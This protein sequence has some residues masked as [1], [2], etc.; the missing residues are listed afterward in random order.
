[1]IWIISGPTSVGKST[2]IARPRSAE[3][4]GLPRGTPVVFAFSKRMA[5][6]LGQT[7]AILHYNILR[8]LQ[9]LR[10][11]AGSADQEGVEL[12]GRLAEF[13]QDPVWTEIVNHTAPK[14]AVVLV[15]SKHTILE[16]IQHRS[17]IEE[18]ALTARKVKAYPNEKW[19]CLLEQV[20]LPDL[21]GAWCQELRNRHIPYVLLDSSDDS[22]RF[23]N[24]EE[25]L[26]ASLTG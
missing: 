22:Y 23:I 12:E 25:Q 1:V 11:F 20:N 7:D 5:E 17:A 8:P 6:Q 18:S 4:T 21:Y 2:F 26:R 14:T 19:E 10:R 3:L 16:R 15:A 9:R 24:G 13:D